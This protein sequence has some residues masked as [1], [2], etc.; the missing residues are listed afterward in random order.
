MTF[1]NA[2]LTNSIDKAKAD[3]DAHG[4]CLIE[5]ALSDAQLGQARTRLIE[6][7]AAE[8]ERG[9]AFRDGGRDQ[10]VLDRAGV[11]RSN[12]F[13]ENDGGVNQR[14]F[15]LVDKG[16]CF[17][18]LVIHPLI[19]EL[20]GHVLG[21][22]FILSTL[23]AN[24]VRSGS[25]RM[26]LHTDQWWMPQPC[27]ADAQY[28]RASNITRHAAPEHLDPDKRLGIAPPVTATAVWMLTDF[29]RQNGTTE[30]VP[31]THLSGAYPEKENQDRYDIVQ[32]EAPAGCLMVFDGRLWHGNGA[33]RGAPDRLGVLATFCA[34]QFRQQENMFLGLS[35]G[36]WHELPDK[37]KARLGY[38][39]WNGYGRV[40][41]Q[42]RGYVSPE[43]RSHG[44]LVPADRND[45]E[46][47]YSQS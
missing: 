34:P 46:Q 28:R 6:Q 39:V 33:N 10:N 35:A 12:A 9:L 5:S 13:S 26:G 23:S 24:I 8:R 27:R 36:R 14:L 44:E 41:S 20:V 47:G 38:R 15:M 17:R 11:F 7:A 29:T 18:D 25:T 2:F 4:V 42:F 1:T 32:L 19:D 31:G 16:Q 30:L 45:F 3:L 40:E 37:L 43:S 22:D 21:D